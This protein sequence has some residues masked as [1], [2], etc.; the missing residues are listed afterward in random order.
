MERR[1]QWM[2]DQAGAA[3][4]SIVVENKTY[5]ET[6]TIRFMEGDI[7]E[8]ECV[9]TNKYAVGEQV[10]MNIYARDG[11]TTHISTIIAIHRNAMFLLNPAELQSKA[12]WKRRNVRL[13]TNI[14]AS[15]VLNA[16]EHQIEAQESVRCLIHDFS[17]GGIGLAVAGSLRLLEQFVYGIQIDLGF[18]FSC[19]IRILHVQTSDTGLKYGA[20]FVHLPKPMEHKLR[21]F[22]LLQQVKAR[23]G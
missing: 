15:I 1:L 14:P 22:I 5:V 19:H 11:M 4:A 6:G 9:Q 20:E 17:A 12:L 21:S 16:G 13:A 18:E 8:V 2:Y 7:I 3:G 10:K 23:I